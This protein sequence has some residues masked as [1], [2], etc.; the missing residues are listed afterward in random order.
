M[1]A[2][3]R[4]RCDRNEFV[5]ANMGLVYTCARRLQGR[6]VEFED[7]VQAGCVGLIKA[8]DAFDTSRGLA[9]STYAV[10]VILG[11]IKRLFREGGAVKVGRTIKDRARELLRKKE[12]LAEELGREPGI[13]ELAAAA[14]LDVSEAAMLL[15]SAMPVI[16]LTMSEEHPGSELDLPVDSPAQA[17]SDRIALREVLEDL[18]LNDRRLIEYRYYGS[19]TQT[20]VADRL[21]MT[22]VQ[23]SR[24]EKAILQRLRGY[25][26]Q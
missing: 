17:I 7:L 9:F 20:Q 25:L 12:L 5:E 8:S 13:A 23:V 6:G 1:P 21:G 16:S 26:L 3:T 18:D 24:R 11:E 15:S 10:P 19:M 14:G 2:E 4:T 22:Q